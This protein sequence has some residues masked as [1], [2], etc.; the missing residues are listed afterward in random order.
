MNLFVSATSLGTQAP[1]HPLV[2]TFDA[3]VFGPSNAKL[4]ASLDNISTPNGG[5]VAYNTYLL[6]P[7]NSPVSL[8]ALTTAATATAI[9]PITSGYSLRQV[10]T[11]TPTSTGTS[12]FSANAIA[13]VPDGG[14]TVAMLGSALF[15]V[16]LLRRRFGV[17]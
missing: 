5:S 12:N 3:G 10:I 6:D 16:G 11:F 15:A 1:T 17:R 7:P 2:V 13:D 9:L 4:T 14:W 8:T